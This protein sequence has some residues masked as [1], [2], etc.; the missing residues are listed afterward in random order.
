MGRFLGCLHDHLLCLIPTV[1]EASRTDM[2]RLSEF[3]IETFRLSYGRSLFSYKHSAWICASALS[4]VFF[5]YKF[6]HRNI[7][8]RFDVAQIPL[9]SFSSG[10]RICY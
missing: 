9:L 10:H 6:C 3:V 7:P 8:N 2:T 5:Q 4:L 1:E